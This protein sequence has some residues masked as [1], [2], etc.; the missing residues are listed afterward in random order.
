[1]L[2]KQKSMCLFQVCHYPEGGVQISKR[3]CPNPY[4]NFF[5]D[6]SFVSDCNT[7]I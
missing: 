6:N 5:F 4:P 3:V 2:I 1:M 7:L